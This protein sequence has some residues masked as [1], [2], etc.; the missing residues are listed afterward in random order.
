MYLGKA[1]LNKSHFTITCFL[2]PVSLLRRIPINGGEGSGG[3][4]PLSLYCTTRG[5]FPTILEVHFKRLHKM[6]G[7]CQATLCF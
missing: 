4:N 6:W 5:H 7:K 1:G 3:G 2:K